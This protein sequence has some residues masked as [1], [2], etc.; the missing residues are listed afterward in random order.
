[1][2]LVLGINVNCINI[3]FSD[4]VTSERTKTEAFRAGLEYRKTSNGRTGT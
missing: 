2:F 4:L 1:M 3:L